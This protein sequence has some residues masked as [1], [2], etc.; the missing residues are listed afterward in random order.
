MP[1][2]IRHCSGW[3]CQHPG[4]K[5]LLNN[6]Y[7]LKINDAS[8]THEELGVFVAS[9]LKVSDKWYCS[10]CLHMISNE[11]KRIKL[12]NKQQ[13]HLWRSCEACASCTIVTHRPNM[14]LVR[15]DYAMGRFA[16]LSNGP[17]EPIQYLPHPQPKRAPP[18]LLRQQQLPAGDLWNEQPATPHYLPVP[19]TNAP[20]HDHVIAQPPPDGGFA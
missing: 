12:Q 9:W 11:S 13:S 16:R 6:D 14:S 3:D 4:T 2:F 1:V 15:P 5:I 20:V 7:C 19:P 10:Q 18:T 17:L 8:C